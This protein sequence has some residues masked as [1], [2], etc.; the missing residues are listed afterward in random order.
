MK[1]VV[2]SICATMYLLSSG[3]GFAQSFEGDGTSANPYRGTVPSSQTWIGEEIYANN[4]VIPSGVTLTISPGMY[5]ASFLRMISSTLTIVSGGAFVLDPNTSAT[6]RTILNDGLLRLESTP[7]ELGV[8][9][10]RHSNYSGSGNAQVRLYL[11][12]GEIGEDYRWHYISLPISGVTATSF[13]T[14]NLARYIESLATSTDNFPGWVAYDGYQYSSEATLPAYAFSNL[15]LGVG[16]NYYSTSSN[17][18]TFEGVPNIGDVECNLSWSGD[19]EFQ[20]YN[21]IGNPYV[22]CLNWETLINLGGLTS[23]DNAI[24]FTTNGAMAAYV[25]GASVNG[26]T[27]FIPP[28]QGFFVKATAV[29]G[30]V[31]F[32][33]AARAHDPDQTRY[34]KKS[35]EGNQVISDTISLVRLSLTAPND[36][37]DLIVRFNKKATTGFDKI[38]DAH[39]F[40]RT[41][42][43]L[44]VWTTTGSIDYAINALPYPDQTVE[45]PVN[46]NMKTGGTFRLG[47]NEIKKLDIYNIFLK[48]IITG[49]IANLL[50][51]EYLE[52]SSDARM[53]EN[54]FVLVITKSATDISQIDE[55]GKWF[56][57]YTTLGKQVNIR[58]NNNRSDIINGRVEIYDLSGK[59]LLQSDNIEWS[60]SGDEK[61]IHL[62]KAS[63]GIYVVVVETDLGRFVEKVVLK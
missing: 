22:S 63:S 36:K 53:V 7:G 14:L 42:G 32:D 49:Q 3:L 62:D 52:F 5:E 47:S 29:N 11:S 33:P 21:L 1:K 55:T 46:I 20:G 31:Y 13:S 6:I 38:Y 18:L 48:D 59:R 25:A 4:I 16:Y 10:L 39:L 24:Y 61:Q 57:I 27:E 40:S 35:T 44:N 8:A 43:D 26:G 41:M 15:E 45:L 50:Q 23:V 12:G 37:S 17:V 34:K 30:Q 58:Q 60:G 56:S 2:F 9:S 51:G 54:R 28:M 19:S